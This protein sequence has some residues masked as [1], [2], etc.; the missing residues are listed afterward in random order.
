MEDCVI[1]YC[2]ANSP[3]IYWNHIDALD[4]NQ[5][6]AQ[7]AIFIQIHQMASRAEKKYLENIGVSADLALHN[8]GLAVLPQH[9]LK[10]V[11][12]NLIARQI[13]FCKD[14]HRHLLFCETTNRYSTA[15]MLKY[16][17]TMIAKHHYCE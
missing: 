8:A 4:P 1:G 17:F 3:T 15:I 6:N 16:G 10:G 5:Y 13:D 2:S 9:R 12:S 7:T 11:G 14:T